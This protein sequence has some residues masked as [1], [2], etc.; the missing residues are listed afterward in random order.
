MSMGSEIMNGFEKAME[1]LPRELRRRVEDRGTDRVEELRLRRGRAPEI[2]LPGER[3]SLD[4]PPVE[5]ELIMRVLEKATGASIHTASAE[6]RGGYISYGG[7]RIGVCG[8]GVIRDGALAGFRDYSSLNIR[9]PR[10]HRGICDSLIQSLYTAGFENTLIISPPGGGK[11]TALR[12][13]IRR[14]SDRGL[15][16]AVADERN[17]LSAS[18]GGQAQFDLGRRSDVLVGVGKAEAAI[19]LLRGMGPEIIA[20][21]EI[22]QERDIEA[23]TQVIG[24]GVGILATA[25]AE[26]AESLDR[27]PLYRELLDRQIF[28]NI[29]TIRQKGGARIYE[30]RRL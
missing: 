2:I 30:A 9:I 6:L 4:G 1:L 10:E 23:V 22:T 24:C 16:L 11:T 27:R 25:H 7:L 26:S 13:F 20:M 17:E 28:K 15:T 5:E 18:E 21:D 3:I 8:T 14:L 29:V 12:E 19:M